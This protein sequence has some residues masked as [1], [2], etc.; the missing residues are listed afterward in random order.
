M[1]R[2]SEI[3]LSTQKPRYGQGARDT[4]IH[5]PTMLW[6]GRKSYYY[7]YRNHVMGRTLEIQL[8]PMAC[9]NHVMGRAL[10]IQLSIQKLCY[11][12]GARDTTIHTYRNQAEQGAKYTTIYTGTTLWPGRQGCNYPYRKHAMDTSTI[13]LPQP[14]T[15]H[16]HVA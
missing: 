1:G 5:T 2:A 15:H 14:L 3:Q 11:G 8:H 13:T 16:H 10:E 6:A 7:P 4:I 12:T 9:R